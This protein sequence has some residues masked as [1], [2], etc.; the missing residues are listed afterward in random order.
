MMNETGDHARNNRSNPTEPEV[1][2]WRHLSN[3]QLAGL[4][5]R[6]QHRVD[7][8][9]LDFFWP[10]IALGVE[11]DG[12]THDPDTDRVR[13]TYLYQQQGITVIRVT[14]IDV[15]T[16]MEGVLFAILDAASKQPARWPDSG[17]LLPNPSSEEGGL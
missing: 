5:F 16:N 11:V 2:L 7:G 13:D 17:A 4:K 1:R 10:A 6:R 12:H 9:I 3:R 14:N 8:R 15:M